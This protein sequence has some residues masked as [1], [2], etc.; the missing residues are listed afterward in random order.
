MA[1]LLMDAPWV[2]NA[3]R[4]GYAHKPEEEE[5]EISMDDVAEWLVDMVTDDWGRDVVADFLRGIQYARRMKSGVGGLLLDV[6][7]AYEDEIRK[8]MEDRI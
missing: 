6:K 4:Y 3:E 5:I 1:T 2:T 8:W 7:D